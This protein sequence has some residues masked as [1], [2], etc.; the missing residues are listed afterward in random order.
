MTSS[1]SFSNS[2]SNPGSGSGSASSSHHPIQQYINLLSQPN[3]SPSYIITIVHKC[4]SDPNVYAGFSELSALLLAHITTTSGNNSAQLQSILRT[5]HL[6]SQGTYLDYVNVNVNTTT[7]TTTTAEDTN[8]YINLN[9]SQLTKLKVL[10]IVT[11]VQQSLDEANQG[12]SKAQK[13]PAIDIEAS[14]T[15]TSSSSSSSSS[16]RSR[17]KR[18]NRVHQNN[19]NLTSNKNEKTTTT[20]TTNN[21]NIGIVP[22]SKLQKALQISN[23]IES[24]SSST[25]TTTREFEDLLIQSIYS[26]LLPSGTKLDQKNMCLIIQL[27][28]DGV[29]SAS[30][31]SHHHHHHVLCRDVN[32]EKDVPDMISKLEAFYKSGD[33]MK[34]HL[35]KCLYMLNANMVEDEMKWKEVDESIMVTRS[36]VFEGKSSSG[37]GDG[38]GTASS[39]MDVEGGNDGWSIAN[40]AKNRMKRSRGGRTSRT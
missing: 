19:S 1:S 26:N 28:S 9:N 29:S 36:K 33:E 11:A 5:L 27:S 7:T 3:P 24:S 34:I 22:Y 15:T 13:H 12:T 39:R 23:N 16:H 4:L 21:K 17:K 6:F 35:K 25:T 40:F 14:T 32:I 37:G 20:T 10:T 2:N 8:T 18:H 38:G 31:E 30:S